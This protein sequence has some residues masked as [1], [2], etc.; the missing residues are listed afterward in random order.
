MHLPSTLPM[1]DEDGTP[2]CIE[3]H[4][5]M[6]GEREA[7][8]E[9]QCTLTDTIL[10]MGWNK[11]EGVPA[12]YTFPQAKT[13]LPA[14]MITIVDDF[15]IA[16]KGTEIGLATCRA[17]KEKFRELTMQIEP[18]SFAGYKLARDRANHAVTLS[19]PRKI[20]EAA[21]TH[22]PQVFEGG[23]K[24]NVLSKCKLINV[25]DGLELDPETEQGKQTT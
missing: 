7:G 11:C 23:A 17:L 12:M 15:L 1:L 13:E 6:W 3:L 18:D 16:G 20:I 9:W 10:K 14:A 4:T 24:A 2:L 25:A 22:L 21:R 8:Y 19:M 5:P